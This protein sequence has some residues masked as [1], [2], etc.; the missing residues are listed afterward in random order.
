M[1]PF[2]PTHYCKMDSI[3]VKSSALPT[4]NYIGYKLD[5]CIFNNLKISNMKT[6]NYDQHSDHLGVSYVVSL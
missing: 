3:F 5:G 6:H 4:N 2:K 1:L